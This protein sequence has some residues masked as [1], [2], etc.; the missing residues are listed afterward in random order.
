[1]TDE[2]Q[3]LVDLLGDPWTEQK[4]PR[5][6]KSHRKT[7]QMSE[8][9]ALLR[10]TGSTED[11]IATRVMLDPKTLRKYYSRELDRGATMARQVLVER[12]WDKAI[13]GNASA[14]NFV[15]AEFERGDAKAAREALRER[16]RPA[17]PSAPARKGKKEE[18]QDAAAN[19]A[20]AGGKFAPPPAPR[21]LVDNT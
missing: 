15:R 2:K 17:A 7:V 13:A 1:M 11:E 6:R 20:Q 18:R 9:V 10:A 4:D 14:A 5:G 12:M 19:V 8:K 21:L 3:P 16:E